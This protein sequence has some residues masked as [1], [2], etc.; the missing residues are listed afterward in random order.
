M[1]SNAGSPSGLSVGEGIENQA[2]PEMFGNLYFKGN[3]DRIRLGQTKVKTQKDLSDDLSKFRKDIYVGK[4]IHPVYSSAVAN[5]GMQTQKALLDNYTQDPTDRFGRMQIMDNAA[6]Q[7]SKYDGLSKQAWEFD[8]KDAREL[9]PEA[10]RGRELLHQSSDWSDYQ[11]K[12]NKE[13]LISPYFQVGKEGGFVAPLPPKDVD[14][15]KHFDDINKNYALHNINLL[16]AGQIGNQEVIG[17]VS[18]IPDTQTDVLD[19]L[20]NIKKHGGNIVDPNVIQTKDNILQSEWND[21]NVRDNFVYALE[22]KNGKYQP[23]G[24]NDDQ[25]LAKFKETYKPYL[26][27]EYRQ[28]TKTIPQPREQTGFTKKGGF[29]SDNFSVNQ[30]DVGLFGTN[31][32]GAGVNIAVKGNTKE[33][34]RDFKAPYAIDG[35]GKLV[36]NSTGIFSGRIENV[37]PKVNPVTG[38]VELFAE[39]IK[40]QFRQGTTSKSLVNATTGKKVGNTSK[41]N[42]NQSTSVWLPYNEAE[43][44]VK[45]EIKAATKPKKGGSEGWEATQSMKDAVAKINQDYQKGKGVASG[46]NSSSPT[47]SAAP[48]GKKDPNK[49]DIPNF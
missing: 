23:T 22:H 45:Q 2:K 47:Q 3:E 30:K 27:G 17:Q 4:N 24:L 28:I 6:Q 29:E 12:L 44:D 20:T 15:G 25:M 8:Q 33:A 48:K 9:T 42:I 26:G 10:L 46:G 39:V 43:G 5:V 14:I 18:M 32:Q 21:R 49:E 37:E 34:E 13:G 19:A 35:E 1:A 38:N 16:P 41:A 31:Y 36:P 11:D 7:V 40:P